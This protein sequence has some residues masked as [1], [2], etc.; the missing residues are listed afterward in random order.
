MANVGRIKQVIGPVVDVSFTAEGS[1]L[2]E[3]LNALEIE[4]PNGEKLI[5]EVQQH[6][7][8]DS[9]RAVAMDS[10]DGLVRGMEVI[11]KGVTIS[12]PIGDAIKGRLFNVVGE[13]IDGIGEVKTEHTRSYSP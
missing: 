13:A 11:D 1:K 6:L 5:M 7:G 3:I 4:R 10:T 12:M 8:E 2:P 9:V